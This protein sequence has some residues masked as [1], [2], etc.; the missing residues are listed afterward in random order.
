L[1]LKGAVDFGGVEESHAELDGPVDGGDRF[2]FI[3]RAIGPTHA[4]AAEA[5]RGNVQAFAAERACLHANTPANGLKVRAAAIAPCTPS[6][7]IATLDPQ[8]HGYAPPLPARGA[9]PL[10]AQRKALCP[11]R[12]RR[13]VRIG[14]IPSRVL[15]GRRA[16]RVRSALNEEIAS[17]R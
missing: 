4:H 9:T 12:A 8:Y 16:A 3:C 11:E 5:E 7:M 1:V 14:G 15:G 2:A 13:G 17:C 10:C 6:T